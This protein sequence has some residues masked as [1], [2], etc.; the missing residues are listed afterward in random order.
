MNTKKFARKGPK[1]T[2]RSHTMTAVLMALMMVFLGGVTAHLDTVDTVSTNEQTT[3]GVTDH[4]EATGSERRNARKANVTQRKKNTHR[5]SRAGLQGKRGKRDA[6]YLSAA[7]AGKLRDLRAKSNKFSAHLRAKH[8]KRL[9]IPTPEAQA[10][11]L[12]RMVGGGA[13]LKKW[14]EAVKSEIDFTLSVPYQIDYIF[15]SGIQYGSLKDK[16]V[17][18]RVE[19]L[20]RAV[21]SVY[22]RNLEIKERKWGQWSQG[23]LGKDQTAIQNQFVA[24]TAASGWETYKKKQAE[25]VTKVVNRLKNALTAEI[26]AGGE[27]VTYDKTEKTFSLTFD[28]QAGNEDEEQLETFNERC[29]LPQVQLHLSELYQ[30]HSAILEP[31]AK[32]K[33]QAENLKE[34]HKANPEDAKEM[35][36]LIETSLTL[37]TATRTEKIKGLLKE[38]RRLY[39]LDS[40]K[41]DDWVTQT[42][43]KVMKEFQEKYT[44]QAWTATCGDISWHF[45]SGFKMYF[46]SPMRVKPVTERKGK[47]IT[48]NVPIDDDGYTTVLKANGGYLYTVENPMERV[49]RS[50]PGQGEPKVEMR[51]PQGKEYLHQFETQ[52]RKKNGKIEPSGKT[53]PFDYVGTVT[54]VHVTPSHFT[55]LIGYMGP[56]NGAYVSM[57]DE[58]EGKFTVY[59]DEYSYSRLNLPKVRA[60]AVDMLFKIDS[61]LNRKGDYVGKKLRGWWQEATTKDDVPDPL[62][63]QK[64]DQKLPQ[65]KPRKKAGVNKQNGNSRKSGNPLDIKDIEVGFDPKAGPAQAAS[66]SEMGFAQSPRGPEELNQSI[67][68][69]TKPARPTREKKGPTVPASRRKSS[70]TESATINAELQPFTKDLDYEAKTVA[71]LKELLKAAGLKVSGK[72][73]DLIER[74][75]ANG[76]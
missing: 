58:K 3:T 29:Q 54:H 55:G 53:A 45:H 11:K 48:W 36:D 10:E 63:G 18:I 52:K 34:Y 74:L 40:L 27:V 67:I 68:P 5:R 51:F 62:F 46:A 35:L 2:G 14:V 23:L 16:K 43:N 44:P 39:K 22:A 19:D 56:S 41:K 8:A 26:E 42:K 1:G 9:S 38:V 32:I 57:G 70:S 64:R 7:E 28:G 4:R 17:D 49:K 25:R 20:M 13:S 60:S 12:A 30:A 47:S 50:H 59:G 24:Q 61:A 65:T 72:K 69:L 66:K 76:Q 21:A 33:K 73:A 37:A 31:S 75:T 15:H 6:L 71:E